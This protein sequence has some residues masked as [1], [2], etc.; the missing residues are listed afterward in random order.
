MEITNPA[1]PIAPAVAMAVQKLM[2][3]TTKNDGA[4]LVNM[5][6]SAPVGS[7]NSPTQGRFVDARA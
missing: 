7:T 6:A 4:G 5:I 1:A 2:L 3:D